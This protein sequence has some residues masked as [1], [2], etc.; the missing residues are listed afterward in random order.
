MGKIQSIRG[1]NPVSSQENVDDGPRYIDAGEETEAD[2]SRVDCEPRRRSTRSRRA[3]QRGRSTPAPRP[4]A[5]AGAY[6]CISDATIILANSRLLQFGTRAYLTL[7]S[8]WQ[9]PA[10]YSL[11]ASARPSGSSLPRHG[12]RWAAWAAA[13][14]W[15]RT[16]LDDHQ[17]RQLT[18]LSNHT[19][20]STPQRP[21]SKIFASAG[22]MIKC[23]RYHGP[24][25]CAHTPSA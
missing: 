24:P 2:T 18:I 23:A 21:P 11:D 10:C 1:E 19:L 12:W 22:T 5:A 14:I 13:S 3:T 16:S 7:P 8:S 4:A 15:P 6:L 25:V 9:T 17:T 20:A